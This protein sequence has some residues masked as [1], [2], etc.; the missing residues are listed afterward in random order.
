MTAGC[1]MCPARYKEG[2]PLNNSSKYIL[3]AREAVQ[4]TKPSRLRKIL[5][6]LGLICIA[7][8]LITS[9]IYCE[10]MPPDILWASRGFLF[11]AT[12]VI[13]LIRGQ[14]IYIPSCFEL[15][16]YPDYMILYRPQRRYNAWTVRR[17]HNKIYY[18][19]I[20][21]CVYFEKSQKFQICGKIHAVW[22]GICKNG[23]PSMEPICNRVVENSICEINTHFIKKLNI[24]E[25]IEKHIPI[26]IIAKNR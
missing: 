25:A 26:N 15:H 12:I 20:S 16:F 10:N 5:K 23:L 18:S 4:S 2:L 21:Q 24:K 3:R 11:L 17:E 22:Y 8:M 7:A 19:D 1:L 14:K 6:I 9:F 13:L